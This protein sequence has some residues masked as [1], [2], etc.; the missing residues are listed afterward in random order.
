MSLLAVSG[1][2]IFAAFA[3]RLKDLVRAIVA[4]GVSSI[5]L[6][7][8]FFL[9]A[10]PFA[11]MLELTVGAGLIVVLFLVA[12]TLSAGSE[13]QVAEGEEIKVAEGGGP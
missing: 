10:S 13:S 8:I 7:M 11:A 5:F 9:L 6:A 1:V 12:L 4:Y 3:V 2:L